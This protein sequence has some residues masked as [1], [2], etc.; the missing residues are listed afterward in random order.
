[1]V[2]LNKLATEDAKSDKVADLGWL[3]YDTASTVSGFQVEDP[4][5][6]ATRMYRLMQDGLS[7]DSL[8]LAEE[9]EVPK[10][11]PKEEEDVEEISEDEEPEKEAEPEKKEEL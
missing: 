10:D 11:E 7:L 1:V 9:V 3:L 4:A 5:A 8:D 2:E 6:F